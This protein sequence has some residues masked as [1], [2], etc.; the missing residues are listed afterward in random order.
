MERDKEHPFLMDFD[1]KTKNL[2]RRR[3]GRKKRIIR[4]YVSQG[5]SDIMLGPQGI[6]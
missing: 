3:E 4:G 2:R 1:L 6:L 5:S